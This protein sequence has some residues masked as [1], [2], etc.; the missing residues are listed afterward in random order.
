[1]GC[2][3]SS[4][5]DAVKSRVVRGANGTHVIIDEFIGELNPLSAAAPDGDNNAGSFRRRARGS[6]RTADEA[7]GSADADG[8]A[9]SRKAKARSAR[10]VASR[11]RDEG[12]RLRAID[13]DA[14][15]IDASQSQSYADIQFDHHLGRSRR[16]EDAQQ[17][18]TACQ[19][20]WV[21]PTPTERSREASVH[22]CGSRTRSAIITRAS[23]VHTDSMFA[24]LPTGTESARDAEDGT[25]DGEH[26]MPP[27]GDDVAA[28]GV[29]EVM[30]LSLHAQHSLSHPPLTV[31]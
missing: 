4:E 17:Q 29:P 5:A 1:M 16:A 26:V 3:Q 18:P 22:Y 11:H 14:S 30:R 25:G 10:E 28:V 31:A 6:T 15:P 13:S 21:I 27:P 24:Q 8:L 19:F 9:A 7:D 20:S 12:L 2:R 23:S